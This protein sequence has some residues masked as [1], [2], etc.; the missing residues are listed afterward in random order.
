MKIRIYKSTGYWFVAVPEDEPPFHRDNLYPFRDWHNAV[1][2][3]CSVMQESTNGN[4][5]ADSTGA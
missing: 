3:A 1:N 5:I 4:P 2:Y